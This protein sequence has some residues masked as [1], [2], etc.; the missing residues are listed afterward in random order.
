MGE[1]YIQNVPVEYMDLQT[2]WSDRRD[3]H[4]NP[5]SSSP[6]REQPRGNPSSL[7]KALEGIYRP[8]VGNDDESKPS[9]PLT[10]KRLYGSERK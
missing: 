8:G 1:Q 3:P 10:N 4:A 2:L 9:A 5:L 7:G 6:R